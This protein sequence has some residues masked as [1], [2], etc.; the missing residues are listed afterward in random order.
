MKLSTLPFLVVAGAM[1]QA[2]ASPVSLASTEGMTSVGPITPGG[3][4][5]TL[6]GTA[7][8]IYEQ[9]LALNPSYNPVDFG[10]KALDLDSPPTV[11]KK[12]FDTLSDLE[13][14]TA[15]GGCCRCLGA[16]YKGEA[17]YGQIDEGA[18]YLW[19]L[20]TRQCTSG[21]SGVSRLTCSYKSA[22]FMISTQL[23]PPVLILETWRTILIDTAKKSQMEMSMGNY[24]ILMGS[25]SLLQPQI[26]DGS[27]VA[28]GAARAADGM[29]IRANLVAGSLLPSSTARKNGCD[30]GFQKIEDVIGV[31]GL[32]P[33]SGFEARPKRTPFLLQ[34]SQAAANGMFL[35]SWM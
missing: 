32:G 15:T 14:R 31:Q 22:I 24:V 11:A 25:V 9:I 34:Y 8:S 19:A 29:R 16:P 30:T 23:T 7:K 17:W 21:P 13:G 1:L 20:G 27:G 10:G 3:P 4:D 28:V 2:Q 26:A 33:G 18:K 5:V 6:S 35:Q 12:S